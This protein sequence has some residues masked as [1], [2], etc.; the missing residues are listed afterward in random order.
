[1]LASFGDT[2]PPVIDGGSC[3]T[4][5][6][7]TIVAIDDDGG[8]RLLR[9]GPVTARKLTDLMGPEAKS[10]GATIEAPGQLAKHYSPGKPVLLNQSRPDAAAFVIGFGKINGDVNLSPAGDLA[11]AASRLYAALHAGAAS[12]NPV[13]AVAPI[14]SEDMGRAI[15][16]R[17][18]RAAA[19]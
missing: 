19:R 5:V 18:Q 1:M 2:A 10:R 12:P 17:L 16:D 9:P 15:N 13:I 8:W 3:D 14:P 11:E 6:E 4:G 7:S